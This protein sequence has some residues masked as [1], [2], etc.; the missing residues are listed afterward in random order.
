VVTIGAP[1]DAAH[2][3][4]FFKDSLKEIEDKGKGRVNLGGKEFSITKSFVQDLK[5]TTLLEGLSHEKKSFLIMHSPTDRYVGI[6][7]AAHIFKALKHP[8]SF[9]SLDDIDHLISKT[10]DAEYISSLISAWVSRYLESDNRIEKSRPSVNE[11]EVK[12]VGRE[13]HQYTHDVFSEKHEIIADEPKSLKG[14]DLGMNPMELL[15]SSLG[16]C[17]AMTTKMYAARK[18]FDLKKVTVDLKHTEGN[19]SKKIELDGD[20]TDEQRKRI[21]EIAEKCPVNKILTNGIQTKSME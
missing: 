16:A 2:I 7:H 9:I 13:G 8:K 1:S 3:I 19:I 18:N 6:E 15:L 21:L 5:E 12:V 17:T 20:L 10:S 11:S 14:E 4:H